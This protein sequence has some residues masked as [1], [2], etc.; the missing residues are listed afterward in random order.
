MRDEGKG[1]EAGSGEERGRRDEEDGGLIDFDEEGK[2]RRSV[3]SG[4]RSA[5]GREKARRSSDRG[6]KG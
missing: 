3:E 5:G 4:A 6:G 2:E 1:Q